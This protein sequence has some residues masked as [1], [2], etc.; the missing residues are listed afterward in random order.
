MRGSEEK[1]YKSIRV[2]GGIFFVGRNC[3]VFFVFMKAANGYAWWSEAFTVSGSER[4]KERKKE[5]K[6]DGE[7]PATLGTTAFRPVEITK[8]HLN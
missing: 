2:Q 4:K 5:R 7:I 8:P 1:K 6:R 3:S